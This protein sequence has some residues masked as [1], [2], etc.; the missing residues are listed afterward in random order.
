MSSPHR[1]INPPALPRPS[2]YSHAIV[3]APGRAVY[4]AGQTA[5]G[6]DGEI[7]GDT[8]TAQ[9]KVA[10]DNLLTALEAAG[11]R[12][13]HLV[14]MQIFVTDVKLYRLALKPIGVAYRERFG[15]HYPAMALLEVSG[16]FDPAALIELQAVAVIP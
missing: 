16:L 1:A 10:A 13:E 12:P 2:G 6:P 4:L 14:S 3:A 5:T 9:F 8:L 7:V 15:K 11:G